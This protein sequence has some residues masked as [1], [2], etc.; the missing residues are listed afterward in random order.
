MCGTMSEDGSVIDGCGKLFGHGGALSSHRKACKTRFVCGCGSAFSSNAAL[1]GHRRTCVIT[2][3]RAAHLP[4][5]DPVACLELKALLKGPAIQPGP[6]DHTVLKVSFSRLRCRAAS[7]ASGHCTDAA[8]ACAESAHQPSGNESADAAA[9]CAESR[10]PQKGEPSTTEGEP[11]S[12]HQPSGNE[13]ADA[14]AACAESRQ[15]QKGEPSTTE[16]EPSSTHQPSGNESA[17]AAAACAKSRQPQKGEPSTTEGGPSSTHQPSVNESADADAAAAH[18][19]SAATQIPR[20]V[21]QLKTPKRDRHPTLKAK[22]QARD[23]V[24]QEVLRQSGEAV[25]GKKIAEHS[26]ECI[27]DAPFTAYLQSLNAARQR[28]RGE[29]TIR[30]VHSDV[31]SLFNIKCLHDEDKNQLSKKDSRTPDIDICLL[32]YRRAVDA[33]RAYS[34]TG[35]LEQAQQHERA[36]RALFDFS[37]FLHDRWPDKVA[38]LRA[39]TDSLQLLKDSAASRR[40]EAQRLTPRRS[41]D[42]RGGRPGTAA[43]ARELRNATARDLKAALAG[44]ME[45]WDRNRHTFNPASDREIMLQLLWLIHNSISVASRPWLLFSHLRVGEP[46]QCLATLSGRQSLRMTDTHIGYLGW[47]QA[48]A[49]F[50]IHRLRGKRVA[51]TPEHAQILHADVTPI[52]ASYLRALLR[53]LFGCADGK[54]ATPADVMQAFLRELQTQQTRK[55]VSPTLTARQENA[56]AI[57]GATRLHAGKFHHV[58]A[59]HLL[60]NNRGRPFTSTNLQTAVEAL[61]LP[62]MFGSRHDA[63]NTTVCDSLGWHASERGELKISMAG[64]MDTSPLHFE[65]TYA[66]MYADGAKER[67]LG[68]WYDLIVTKEVFAFGVR[69][70]PECV[71]LKST[72]GTYS[73]IQYTPA[74]VHNP[75]LQTGESCLVTF[76]RDVGASDSRQG[77]CLPCLSNPTVSCIPMSIVSASKKQVCSEYSFT[78]DA[79]AGMYFRP[80]TGDE[81]V[82]EATQNWLAEQGLTRDD[83]YEHLVRWKHRGRRVASKP[84]VGSILLQASTGT[85]W[86]VQSLGVEDASVT[87]H[88][89]C[90]NDHPI[91]KWRRPLP[92]E[93]MPRTLQVAKSTAECPRGALLLQHLD[94]FSTP[95]R[96][97]IVVCHAGGALSQ[98]LRWQA[99]ADEVS[100]AGCTQCWVDL[101][102]TTGSDSSQGRAASTRAMR[103]RADKVQ[104][105]LEVMQMMDEVDAERMRSGH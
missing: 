78:Y 6:N 10:Q 93:V 23:V 7:V 60:L 94:W 53:Y 45:V 3:K 15:P 102:P 38:E 69:V 62:K 36:L 91:G 95:Q 54:L 82:E 59:P 51:A 58:P 28:T 18:D 98:C 46:P 14:A 87:A 25:L 35:P 77:W 37:S 88:P 104:E 84:R 105:E 33:A 44:A 42:N 34:S 8:A 5:R 99:Q 66:D 72:D 89:L 24:A 31:L 56:A 68:Y 81:A 49:G 76:L 79:V 22:L 80:Q 73:H 26:L 29:V 71:V 65:Q 86:V 55:S 9:A 1:H 13:S 52:L 67:Q 39:H 50:V 57:D 101:C 100:A 97:D 70:L 90:Y 27:D 17:D 48:L 61:M 96:P 40:G 92:T 63:A 20:G 21:Q 47:N 83:A 75:P 41:V 85:P 2:K 64:C 11:S 19:A 74:L 4:K 32:V 103:N 12:T 16:G 30:K 43:E